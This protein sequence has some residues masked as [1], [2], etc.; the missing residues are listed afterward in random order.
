[1]KKIPLIKEYHINK[2]TDCLKCFDK[3][4]FNREKQ[5]ECVLSLYPNKSGRSFEHRE[6][7]I[8][9]GMVIPSLRHLGLIIG[10]EDLLRTSANGKLI[11]ESQRTEEE[12][13]YR[14]WRAIIYE[15]DRDVFGFISVIKNTSF[16]L[17]E[18]IKEISNQIEAV[19]E[20]QKVERI[21]KWLSI[22]GQVALI[23]YSDIINLNKENYEQVIKDIDIN[24]KNI[25]IFK[26]YLFEGY[27]KLTEDY[28][29]VVDIRTLREYVCSKML[30]ANKAILTE[31]QFD[32][33]LRKI[34]FETENYIISLGEPMGAEQKL[35]RY[36]GNYFKTLHIKF[37]KRR[38]EDD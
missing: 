7:S 22:L 27:L 3:Y 16:L 17:E 26:E 20:K 15:I 11:I 34:P 25:N 4:A 14:V 18:F 2:L 23:N 24:F 12:L 21:K 6:K 31:H 5:K 28:G 35:F 32:E 1:M 10:F 37:Y 36:R 19:S 33:I 8:F 13:Y 38:E 30:K 29:G 9:R